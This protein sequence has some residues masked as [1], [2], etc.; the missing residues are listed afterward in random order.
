MLT[1]IV[2]RQFLL[3]CNLHEPLHKL[4]M[5][6]PL[7]CFNQL[8][9]L[10]SKLCCHVRH[11]CYLTI[12]LKVLHYNLYPLKEFLWCYR[13]MDSIKQRRLEFITLK[14]TASSAI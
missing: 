1:N 5:T 14:S 4:T 13:G 2:F 7:I 3:A 6:I 9:L 10:T 8:K 12:L 11:T